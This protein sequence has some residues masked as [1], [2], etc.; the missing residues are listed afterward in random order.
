MMKYF[1]ISEMKAL[2]ELSQHADI[3]FTDPQY[4][5]ERCTNDR[6]KPMCSRFNTVIDKEK[7]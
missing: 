6:F 2:R 7:K 3:V 1:I 5:Y 4:D